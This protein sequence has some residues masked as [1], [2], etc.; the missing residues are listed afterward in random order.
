M[1]GDKKHEHMLF[2]KDL[3]SPFFKKPM[4]TFSSPLVTGWT[5]RLG[6][7][8]RSWGA[9]RWRSWPSETAGFLL[10]PKALR[11]RVPS[12]RWVPHVTDPKLHTLI[13]PPHLYESVMTVIRNQRAEA[14][15]LW[16]VYPDVVGL[17]S[18]VISAWRTVRA[19]TSMKAGL[20]LW[21]WMAAFLFGPLWKDNRAWS[22]HMQS[23][24]EDQMTE[25]HK[26]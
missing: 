25:C 14:S 9:Q 19:A 8:L 17:P 2:I 12:S 21:R 5:M 20:S 18:V 4:L 15:T 6:G 16:D 24:P 11:I 3:S 23:S 7:C 13:S 22:F 26:T 10:E 1:C